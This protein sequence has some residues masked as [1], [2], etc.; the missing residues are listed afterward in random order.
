MAADAK[1]HRVLL[2]L[3]G[4]SFCT[5]EGFGVESAA[6]AGAVDELLPVV[7]LGVQLAIVVGGGNFV[8][9]RDLAD[10][11]TIR[12]VTA[13]YMG[14]LGTVMN[15]IALRDALEARGQAVRVLS[16]LPLA[17]ICEPINARQAVRH[18]QTGCVVLFAGGT[19]SPFF[20][21]D[22][23]AALRASE[24]DAELLIKATKVEGVYDSD[25]MIN[26]NAKMYEQLTYHKALEDE[27]GVMDPAAFALCSDKGIPLVVCQ[28]FMPGNLVKAV[29]GER[30]GT[31]VT[32]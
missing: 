20:T 13:D 22:T 10:D 19:G 18:L 31:L 9:A 15:A 24:I 21:T 30:V 7:N 12:R 32:E 14:M 16:A 8:R 17:T 29:R 6:L 1:Y 3:S 11:P 25:P 5:A 23:A 28:L 4:E 26:P 27:L 2:K